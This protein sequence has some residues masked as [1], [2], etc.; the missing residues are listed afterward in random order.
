MKSYNNILKTI[1][2][3][4]NFAAM[5]KQ[6]A[7]TYRLESHAARNKI[8]IKLEKAILE[9]NKSGSSSTRKLTGDEWNIMDKYTRDLILLN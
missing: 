6:N 1:S 7:L 9:Y 2:E 3:V 5:Y 4:P 8:N